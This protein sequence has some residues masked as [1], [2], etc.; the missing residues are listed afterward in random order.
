MITLLVTMSQQSV[1]PTNSGPLCPSLLL[2]LDRGPGHPCVCAVCTRQVKS[3]VKSCPYLILTRK[4][5][6]MVALRDLGAHGHVLVVLLNYDIDSHAQWSV[7][8]IS[9][10]AHNEPFSAEHGSSVANL[11][12]KQEP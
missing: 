9:T 11:F 6:D 4:H 10:I 7:S 12:I 8:S 1:C 2:T 5:T 3:I